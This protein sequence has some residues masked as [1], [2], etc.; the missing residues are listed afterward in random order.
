MMRQHF[1]DFFTICDSAPVPFAGSKGTKKASCSLVLSG[2]VLRVPNAENLKIRPEFLPNLL[3]L[4]TNAFLDKSAL[5][6]VL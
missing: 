4:F 1:F 6:L 2:S 5:A 3:G